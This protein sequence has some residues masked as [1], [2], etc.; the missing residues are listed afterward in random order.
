[1]SIKKERRTFSEEFKKQIVQLFNAGK[2]KSDI[3][4]EYELSPT[5]IDR[6]IK[7]DQCHRF[8][9]RVR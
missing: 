6:W 4:R 7:T 5:V 9:K 2:P 8:C 3:F 1:M